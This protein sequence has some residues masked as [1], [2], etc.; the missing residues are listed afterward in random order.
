[1]EYDVEKKDRSSQP[2][3]PKELN[4]SNYVVE[5]HNFLYREEDARI[6]LLDRLKDLLYSV[7]HVMPEI[8]MTRF[9]FHRF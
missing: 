3:Q 7:A 5:M 2:F 9:K 1:M 8:L 6:K 4:R